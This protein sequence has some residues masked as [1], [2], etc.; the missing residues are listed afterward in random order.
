MG[1]FSVTRLEIDASAGRNF[2]LDLNNS[3]ANYSPNYASQ[4]KLCVTV[5]LRYI[6][7]L[8]VCGLLCQYLLENSGK[9]YSRG[10]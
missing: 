9:F 8:S 6:Y 4:Y 3:Y 1:V 2:F 7:I 5:Y 10:F